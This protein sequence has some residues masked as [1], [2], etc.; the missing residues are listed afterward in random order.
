M[1]V[2]SKSL[3]SDTDLKYAQ[4]YLPDKTWRIK[5]GS[6]GMYHFVY[7]IINLSNKKFYIGKH[8]SSKLPVRSSDYHGSARHL[9]YAIARY[10]LDSFVML[11]LRYFKSDKAAYSYEERLITP[12]MLSSKR[13]YNWQGGGGGLACG[14]RNPIH[15]RTAQGN[16]PFQRRSDG[17]SLAQETQARLVTKGEHHWLRR[18]DG[19]SHSKE[20]AQRLL[21]E[22]RH[23]LQTKSD[24]SSVTKSL[25]ERG[26]F[27]CLGVAP[28]NNNNA[29]A[30]SLLV[31]SLADKIRKIHTKHPSAGIWKLAG[32]CKEHLDL[33][34][35]TKNKN[36]LSMVIHQLLLKFKEGWS[37]KKDPEWC[38][39]KESLC[40]Q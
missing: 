15:L 37:P 4:E 17:T 12:E 36:S 24:G 38:S 11:I 7:C 13:C 33:S 1:K 34:N 25:V 3:L 20:L 26:V 8:S 10:R 14:E 19:T 40:T 6:D 9:R 35:Y 21:K 30:D 16:N 39:F 2:V 27:H 18:S 22:G 28:W 31:W 23:N 5:R 32:L 29:T